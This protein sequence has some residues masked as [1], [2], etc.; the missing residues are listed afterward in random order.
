MSDQTLTALVVEDEPLARKD[1]ELMLAMESGVE[2]LSGSPDPLQTLASITERKPDVLFLDIRMPG[3]DGFELLSRI[4]TASLPMVVFVSA[5]DE[6]ALRAFEASAMDFLLKPVKPSRLR[7]ALARVRKRRPDHWRAQM[8]GE[9]A[10]LRESLSKLSVERPAAPATSFVKRLVVR[11]TQR[12]RIVDV[13]SIV[14]VEA[15]RNYCVLHC[16]EGRFSHRTTVSEL[17][18]QLDPDRF[19]RVHRSAIVAIAEIQELLPAF[20]GEYLVVLRDGTRLRWSGGYREALKR[21]L[22]DRS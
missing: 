11:E 19:V 3:I 15:D 22:S 14:W 9:I 8:A 6:F 16:R 21:F 7:E 4:P 17:E 20:R 18:Q 10:E 1:L 2:V 5:F 12:I 13:D